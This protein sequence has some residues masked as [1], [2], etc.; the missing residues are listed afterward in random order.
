MKISNDVPAAHRQGILSAASRLFRRRGPGV[1]IAEVTREAG[2]THGGIYNHFESNERLLGE[3]S[4]SALDGKLSLLAKVKNDDGLRAWIRAYAS[5]QHVA[6]PE[7]GCPIAALG[8]DLTREGLAVRAPFA[9]ALP[10]YFGAMKGACG[11]VAA[12]P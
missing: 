4:A 11:T 1:S 5:S 6:R 7:T 8:S 12:R 10:Q 9:A 3:A 2:L